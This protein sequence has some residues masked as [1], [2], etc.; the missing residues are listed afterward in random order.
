MISAISWVPRGAAKAVPEVVEPTEEDLE[1]MREM[2]GEHDSDS[3]M[4]D[5]SDEDPI[6]RA[7]AMA[8]AVKSSSNKGKK[9]DEGTGGLESA[10]KELDMDNYDD[11][12]DTELPG[13][14]GGK[15][16]ETKKDPYLQLG[17]DEDSEIE[18]FNIRER[19]LSSLLLSSCHPS[20]L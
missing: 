1:Q 6:A 14:L 18:D 12:D 17:S 9:S 8:A 2:A 13:L 11:E 4:D 16:G 20:S 15:F 7:L 3:D 10:L 5:D 19:F